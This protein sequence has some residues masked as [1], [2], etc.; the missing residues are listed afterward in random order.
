MALTPWNRQE[1]W[2][3]QIINA[4]TGKYLPSVSAQDAGKVLTVGDNGSW[5]ADAIPKELPAVETT[6]KDKYLHTN[7]S[8][9]AL[10]WV[11]SDNI[12]T[13]TN[14]DDVQNPEENRLYRVKRAV[15]FSK[16]GSED[17]YQYEINDNTTIVCVSSLPV[18]NQIP[19]T[20]DMNTFTYY[21]SDTDDENIY[22]W[23]TEAI[24]SQYGI[25]EGWY[26]FA[27]LGALLSV[28]WG[29][30]YADPTEAEA[31]NSKF[32]ALVY[33]DF[34]SFNGGVWNYITQVKE[35][36][37]KLG[38]LATVEGDF[39]RNEASGD[40]SHSEGQKT[41]AE[42]EYSHA[43]GFMTVARGSCS[44][45]EGSE[46]AATG[47]YSHAENN[48]FA[49]G[50]LSHSEGSY[51]YANATASH[52]EGIATSANGIASHAEGSE[53]HAYGD[54]SH[55]EG[56]NTIAN[57]YAQHVFGMYNIPDIQSA[58]SRGNYV[59]IVGNGTATGVESNARTLDWSGNEKLAGGLTLGMGTADETTITAAQLKALLAMLN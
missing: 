30:V 54:D 18:S 41:N 28:T 19:V 1:E 20:T 6:D 42:G 55:A 53:T 31:G 49:D 56:Y 5:E 13:V 44:H 59:E 23:V 43:E 40:F 36:T 4:S 21:L 17:E 14:T 22:G 57:S 25:P 15:L 37:N 26:T 27:V 10:E 51:T 12:I 48:S 34:A 35:Y 46:S 47:N 11:A 33:Y 7:A 9:G 32:N 38:M 45:A 58:E 16:Y 2:Y 39:L 8:T 50:A 24:G 29:G 52:S 3:Q